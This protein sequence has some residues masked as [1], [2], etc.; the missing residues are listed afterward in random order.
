MSELPVMGWFRQFFSTI[1]K[2]L[3]CST[4]GGGGGG[5]QVLTVELL[6]HVLPAPLWSGPWQATCQRNALINRRPGFTAAAWCLVEVWKSIKSCC[7][8][9]GGCG[10]GIKQDEVLSTWF[11]LLWLPQM[12]EH[13][14]AQPVRVT[15]DPASP[16]VGQSRNYTHNKRAC[17][18]RGTGEQRHPVV[19]LRTR[20]LLFN[21]LLFYFL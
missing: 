2:F 6:L 3:P 12:T 17:Q 13:G 4:W 16:P 20:R 21:R 5:G 15:S 8:M 14:P 10:G 18:K 7:G 1:F 11:T 19:R 9:G